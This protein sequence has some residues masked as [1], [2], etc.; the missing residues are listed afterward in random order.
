[1]SNRQ[2]RNSIG[3]RHEHNVIRKIVYREPPNFSVWNFWDGRA[4]R[5]EALDQLERA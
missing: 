3:E 5:R 1:M 2:Y 4:S